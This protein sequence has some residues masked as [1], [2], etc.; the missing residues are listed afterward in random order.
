MI[1]FGKPVHRWRQARMGFTLIELLVVITILGILASIVF[2]ALNRARERANVLNTKTT[3]TKLHSQIQMKWDSYRTRK[4][5]VNPQQ[6]LQQLA[7]T[8]GA[9]NP[10]VYNWLQYWGLV[11]A[12]Y[13]PSPLNNRH[14]AA[15]RLLALRELQ[16]LEMPQDWNDVTSNFATGT[17]GNYQ[18]VS[19]NVLSTWPSL[20]LGYL[21]RLNAAVSP[22]TGTQPTAAQL[23]AFQPAE[24]LYMI[25]TSGIDDV[26]FGG[27][28]SVPKSVGDA[29]GDG[30]PEFQDAWSNASQQFVVQGPQRQPIYWLRTPAGFHDSTLNGITVSDLDPDPTFPL[31]PAGT[32]QCLTFSRGYHDYFDTMKIDLPVPNAYPLANTTYSE[33]GLPRGYSLAPLVVSAGPD[34]RFGLYPDGPDGQYAYVFADLN[35]PYTVDTNNGLTHGAPITAANLPMGWNTPLNQLPEW[36]DN[37]HSHLVEIR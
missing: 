36:T 34:G 28:I 9:S 21:R 33:T 29:D 6:I 30:L 3:I 22:A 10:Y 19:L 31:L 1:A 7:L 14:V 15:V 23:G 25:I 4:V 13:P 11:N 12:G 35:D 17:P 5:P 26:A 27:E 8:S 24:C 37:I 32:S 18:P 20:S 2:A 16:R